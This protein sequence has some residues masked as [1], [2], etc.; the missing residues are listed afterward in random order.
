MY[1]TTGMTNRMTGSDDSI[2]ASMA[3]ENINAGTR[4]RDFMLAP[5]I[6]L[7]L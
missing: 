7:A 2:N 6:M 5:V 3:I 1:D 4:R